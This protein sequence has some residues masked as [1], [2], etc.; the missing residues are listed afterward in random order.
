[1]QTFRFSA[2]ALVFVLGL[3]IASGAL[4][5]QTNPHMTTAQEHMRTTV[6]QAE[7]TD[8]ETYNC[9]RPGGGHGD[10]YGGHRL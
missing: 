3:G 5:A 10:N 4:A 8:T 7:A 2:I 6:H 1:M 9:P